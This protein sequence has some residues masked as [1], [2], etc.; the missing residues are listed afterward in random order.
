MET[1]HGSVKHRGKH[2]ALLQHGPPPP[3]PPDTSSLLWSTAAHPSWPGPRGQGWGSEAPAEHLPAQGADMSWRGYGEARWCERGSLPTPP[4]PK[5][6]ATRPS[7]LDASHQVEQ[8]AS[9]SEAIVMSSS[10]Q[11]EQGYPRHA[12]P[13]FMEES[14]PKV[15][16]PSG[17]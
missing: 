5:G 9:S 2:R 11:R 6:A 15:I 14:Q 4:A 10:I 3:P 17:S 8:V 7:S 12:R 1:E 13:C 16:F